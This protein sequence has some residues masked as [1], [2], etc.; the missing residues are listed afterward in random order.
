MS[1]AQRDDAPRRRTGR[2]DHY[3]WWEYV[4]MVFTVLIILAGAALLINVVISSSEPSPTATAPPVVNMDCPSSGWFDAATGTCVPKVEC[5]NGKVRDDTTNTCVL[6]PPIV[7]GVAPRTGPAKGGTELTVTGSG[8]TEGAEVLINGATGVG[9]RVVNA[10]TIATTTPPSDVYYPVDIQ[11]TNSDGQVDVLDNVFTYE[12]PPVQNITEIVPPDGSSDGGEAVIIKGLDFQQGAVV[13]FYGRPATDVEV[14]DASTIRATI[15][16]A[17]VGT[18]TV[19]VRN[20]GMDAY[21]LQDGFEYVDRPPRVVMAV[22]P[23]QGGIAGGTEITIVGT[24]F[25]SDATVLVG[26]KKASKVDVVDSTKITAVT[27]KGA[28]GPVMVAVRNP[29]MPAAQLPDGFEFVEAP[30]ITAVE[31]AEGPE[32]GDTKVTITGTDFLDGATVTIGNV[33]VPKVKVVNDTT[34]TFV[35]PAAAQPITVD[36]TVTNPEQPPATVKKA[37]TYTEVVLPRCRPIRLPAMVVPPGQDAILTD[38]DLFS[39]S[40]DLQAPVLAGATLAGE[41]AVAWTAS[42]PRI[43]WTA[44]ATVGASGTVTFRYIDPSCRGTGSGVQRLSAG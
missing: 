2:R 9:T 34:I 29:G 24:G 27:P 33:T 20:P 21:V 39:A 23:K 38:A 26:G 18:V 11:V 25:A 36:I 22:R 28:L 12:A 15:P 4:L 1:S 16:A 10:T 14:L 7:T 42:P 31:P 44:P 41:G 32:T 17:P 8:F 3:A 19:N 13:S 5:K 30:T 40:R 37:F 6:A 43:T 35:T